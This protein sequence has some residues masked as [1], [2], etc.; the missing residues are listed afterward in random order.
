MQAFPDGVFFEAELPLAW[1]RQRCWQPL[2]VA[3]YFD[4]LA[5]F[6]VVDRADAAD[7]HQAKLDLQ[8]VWLARL[9]T[10]SLPAKVAVTVGLESVR[11]LAADLEP[12]ERGCLAIAPGAALPHLLALPAEIFD[13]DASPQGTVVTARWCFDHAG[14]KDAFERYVFR[15]HRE[16]I[17][18]GRGGEA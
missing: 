3:R 2:E 5:D 9:M 8:L 14:A 7:V 17:R 12:G 13:V 4:V 1:Q 16:Q 15:R 10:P 11:W 6:E 18:H